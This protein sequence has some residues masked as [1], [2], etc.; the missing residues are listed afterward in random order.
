MLTDEAKRLMEEGRLNVDDWDE[1][2]A[3]L[4]LKPEPFCSGM[5]TAK[6]GQGAERDKVINEAARH[7]IE[8]DDIFNG[9]LSPRLEKVMMDALHVTIADVECMTE[10]ELDNLYEKACDYEEDMAFNACEKTEAGLS[11]EA[12]DAAH[13]VDWIASR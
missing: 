1:E 6:I 10:E 7:I 5:I 2:G 12:E 13:L 8:V 11:Q 3:T 9:K 4:I